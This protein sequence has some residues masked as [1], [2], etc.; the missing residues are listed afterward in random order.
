VPYALTATDPLP[1]EP[2]LT[3]AEYRQAPTGVD[4]TG[5]VKGDQAASLAELGNVIARASSWA[6]S[7][8][9]Q[10]LAASV[11]VEAGRVAI[12][13]D[14]MLRIH[15]RQTPII[16]VTGVSYGGSPNALTP[17]TD[18]SS[19]WVESTEFLAPLLGLTGWSNSFVGPLGFSAV[20][21][22][23]TVFAQW[24]Y[25][26]GW[27]NTTLVAAA[28]AG[29]TQVTVTNAVGVT[30][31]TQLTVYDGAQTEMVT[32]AST[33]IPGATIL[34]LAAGLQFAHSQTGISV[35][36]LPPAVKQ[37]VILLTSALIRTRGASALVMQSVRGDVGRQQAKSESGGIEEID[38][39][40]EL[41]APFRRVW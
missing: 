1:S 9:G 28:T 33:Y 21:P 32:V 20:R 10:V 2:Y 25:V 27:P 24:S 41:L 13:R 6:D 5:L 19:L 14:G 26:A 30:P 11:D 34:P 35:S 8:C 3:T 39:A 36:A 7:L 40:D 22:G 18:L 16:E 31:G 12:S 23:Q 4:T 17:L 15:P 38:L 37:A 29:A